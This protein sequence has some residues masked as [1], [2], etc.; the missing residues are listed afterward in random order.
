MRQLTGLLRVIHK[1]E[2]TQFYTSILSYRASQA[3]ELPSL[4]DFLALTLKES[5][6][7]ENSFDPAADEFLEAHA[8]KLLEEKKRQNV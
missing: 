2:L 4:N 6:T 7:K 8:K 3:K 1:A 5:P